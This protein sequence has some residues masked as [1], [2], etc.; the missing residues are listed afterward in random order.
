MTTIFNLNS[1]Y[2]TRIAQS[3]QRLGPD[4]RSLDEV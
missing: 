4:E 3:K 2:S 1:N